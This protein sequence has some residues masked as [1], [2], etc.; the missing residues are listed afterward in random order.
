M[1]ASVRIEDEAFSDPRYDM[2]GVLAGYN[3]YE[4][5]GRMACLWRHCTHRESAVVSAKLV[6]AFLGERGPAAIIEADLGELADGGIRVKGTSGRIEWLRDLRAKSKVGGEANRAKRSATA[7]ATPMDSRM[8]IPGDG[9][10]SL[11]A[12]PADQHTAI[13]KD[14]LQS[15]QAKPKPSPL[16]TYSINTEEE[17]P[18]YPPKSGGEKKIDDATKVPIPANL[19][20]D[21]FRAAWTMWIEDR[22]RRKKKITEHAADLQLRKLA[23]FDI[24]TAIRIIEKAITSGWTG[25]VFEGYGAAN[26]TGPVRPNSRVEYDPTRNGV[27]PVIVCGDQTPAEAATDDVGEQAARDRRG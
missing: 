8:A 3:R 15:A 1:A 12:I 26:G 10:S 27:K 21:D 5:L 17:E 9:G 7:P 11:T 20:R 19:D 2:L 23:A 16:I 6:A 24:A 18:P 4:A 13:P 22:S 14:S 25:L